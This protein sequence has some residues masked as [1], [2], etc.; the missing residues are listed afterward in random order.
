PYGWPDWSDADKEWARTEFESI[1]FLDVGSSMANLEWICTEIRARTGAHILLYNLSAVVPGE[2]VHCF[3]GL[4]ETLPTRIRRFN[5]AAV[6]LSRRKGISLVD[7]D[8][9][10]A[11]GGADRLKLGPVHVRA[12]GHRLIAHEVIRILSDLGC[13][14][15]MQEPLRHSG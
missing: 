8:S 5:L 1:G 4:E 9:I 15:E 14:E 2:Q 12:E 6:E 11:R 3:Q 7:V 13:F 10:I